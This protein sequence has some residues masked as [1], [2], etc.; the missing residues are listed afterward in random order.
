MGYILLVEVWCR[1]S[2]WLL[3]VLY[4]V[5]FVSCR[6]NFLWGR[7]CGWFHTKG[8]WAGLFSLRPVEEVSDAITQV[9]CEVC[10]Y[11][12]INSMI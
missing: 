8:T 9:A 7:M 6:G 10:T 12:Q 2:C 11:K 3:P 1:F 4:C 5:S